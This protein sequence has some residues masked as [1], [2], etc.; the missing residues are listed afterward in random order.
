MKIR[1]KNCYRVLNNNEEYCTKCGEHS[2]EIQRIMETGEIPTDEVA[3]FKLHLYL[4]LGIAFLLNGALFVLNGVLFDHMYPGGEYGE[5]GDAMPKNITYFSSINALIVTS[6][7]MFLIVLIF[8]I[9]Q[10]ALDYKV[11]SIKR[12]IISFVIMSGITYG[13]IYLTKTTNIIAI[14]IYMKDYI[15]GNIPNTELFE[16]SLSTWKIALVLGLYVF[17]QEYIFRKHLAAALDDGTLF[18][19]PTTIIVMTLASAVL[20]T[21]CFSVFSSGT[22]EYVVYTFIG[23][24]I[25]QGML[26]INYYFNKQTLAINIILRIL[27]IVGIIILL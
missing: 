11:T 15:Q 9:K 24:L 20:E 12:A 22:F 6:V 16:N 26:T 17:V 3:S 21:I 25:Y 23:S 14:P 19:L 18:S 13:I 27:F 5:I 4:Y 7:I 10:I 8:N 2:D 1:C